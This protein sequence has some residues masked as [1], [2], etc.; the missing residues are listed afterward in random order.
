MCQLGKALLLKNILSAV[1]FLLADYP[2]HTDRPG[3]GVFWLEK[4]GEK[5]NAA[6]NFFPTYKY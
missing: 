3:A 4:M 6:L 1:L 5:I 2:W